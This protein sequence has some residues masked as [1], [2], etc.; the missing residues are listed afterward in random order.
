MSLGRAMRRGA[1]LEKFYLCSEVDADPEPGYRHGPRGSVGSSPPSAPPRAEICLRKGSNGYRWE[2]LPFPADGST[3]SGSCPR[4]GSKPPVVAYGTAG[5]L[6]ATVMVLR[7]ATSLA[8]GTRRLFSRSR[9]TGSL[10]GRG[11]PRRSRPGRRHHQDRRIPSPR[12]LVGLRTQRAHLRRV[13]PRCSHRRSGSAASRR[14]DVLV[15]Q[16]LRRG[17]R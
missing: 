17:P 7:P 3:S 13:V 2:R 10:R 6:C 5:A 15:L 14:V 8:R 12:I 16:G 9:W 4:D 11:A 1:L